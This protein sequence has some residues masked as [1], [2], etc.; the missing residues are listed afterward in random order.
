MGIPSFDAVIALAGRQGPEDI[1]ASLLLS[2]ATFIAAADG[3]ADYV[4]RLGLLP[5]LVIG[6]FDSIEGGRDRRFTAP[7]ETIF[8]PVDKY[9]TDGE[10]ALAAA[11][12]H[13]IGKPLPQDEFEL[14]STFEQCNN[15]SGITLLFLNYFGSR[16]DHTMANVALAVLAARR[17]ADVFL[18]DG[19]T[20]GRVAVGPMTLSPVFHRDFF[21][22]AGDRPFL[23]SAQALDDVSGLT[24]E[25]LRWELNDANLT[26]ARSLALS[27]R[28]HTNHPDEVRLR[29]HR[30]TLALFTFPANL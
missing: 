25:G 9:H 17:G 14:Y 13:I 8:F 16:H 30:G 29:C 23:F 21:A 6:D 18:T 7:T 5:D 28:A 20:L 11:V 26:P 1:F 24:L 12:L 27:N 10:L 15:F 2:R 22:R 3:G 4:M 19:T